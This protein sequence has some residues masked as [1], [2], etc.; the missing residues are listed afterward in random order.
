[1]QFAPDTERNLLKNIAIQRIAAFRNL[2]HQEQENAI[3]YAILNIA[4]YLEDGLSEA[5]SKEYFITIQKV[6]NNNLN[7]LQETSA[8]LLT[9]ARAVIAEA[10]SYLTHIDIHGPSLFNKNEH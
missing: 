10:S 9:S 6:L 2:A 3:K 5:N 4:F 8:Y 7:I 1:M